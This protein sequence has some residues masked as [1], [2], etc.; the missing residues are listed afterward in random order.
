MGCL[1]GYLLRCAWLGAWCPF[2]VLHAA[3]SAAELVRRLPVGGLSPSQAIASRVGAFASLTSP[4]EL[5]TAALVTATQISM[6][7][8]DASPCRSSPPA[9]YYRRGYCYLQLSSAERRATAIYSPLLLLPTT[10]TK[11]GKHSPG[12][13]TNAAG[14]KPVRSRSTTRRTH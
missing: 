13:P 2:S 14:T 12:N 4:E 7:A 1:E 10:Q 11:V 9:A 5:C 6:A 8:E 3:S